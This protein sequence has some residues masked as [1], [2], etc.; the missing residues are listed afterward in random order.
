MPRDHVDHDS[1]RND[2]D[3][4]FELAH[5]GGLMIV[6]A[7]RDRTHP[8]CPLLRLPHVPGLDSAPPRTLGG[9]ARRHGARQRSA[10][11]I[12]RVEGERLSV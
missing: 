5:R 9:T 10:L 7:A 1:T 11:R 4:P 3:R 12:A 8:R 2:H 6:I